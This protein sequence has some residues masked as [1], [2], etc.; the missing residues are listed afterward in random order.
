MGKIYWLV[1]SDCGYMQ[2]VYSEEELYAFEKCPICGGYMAW[3][4]S[5]SEEENRVKSSNTFIGN[6]ITQNDIE[7]FRIDLDTLSVEEI[8]NSWK[9]K[10]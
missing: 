2:K 5:R 1:C 9:M 10:I 4:M 6:T 8:L 3:D 7:D